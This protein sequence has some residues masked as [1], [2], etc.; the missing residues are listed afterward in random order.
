MSKTFKVAVV[1]CGGIA[2][3][4]HLPALQAQKNVEIVWF[5]DIIEERA[6]KA[7]EKYGAE[8]A[9]VTTD[10]KDVIADETVDVVHVLT[11][12]REH[13][14]ITIDAL[15]SGKHV[16]C[17]KPMAKTAKE[18]A[19]MVAA[20]KRSG[21]KLSIGYQGRHRTDS[22]YLKALVEDGELGEIYY[23]KAQAIRRRGV[24]TWGV[25]LDEDAQGGGPLIDIG[26][27][28]LDLTLWLMDNYEVD[29]VVGN[30]YRKLGDRENAANGF[31]PWD[32]K[33]F[34]VEDSAFGFITMKNGATI[35]L[36]SS[37]AL[38]I[39]DPIESASVLCGTEGGADMLD[40]LRINGE[41]HSRLYEW[42]PELQSGG[43]AFYDGDANE[44]ESFRECRLFYKSIEDNS[45]PVVTPEQALVV[46]QVLEAIYES[47]KTRRPVYFDEAFPKK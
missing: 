42:K 15:D 26:T 18:A 36:E 34:T 3:G 6:V 30:S 23:A 21:K 2:E 13:S 5:C 7:A 32:P 17:E 12:N 29:Y 37:W 28:A 45:D 40:G 44:R 16:L 9:K 8:G 1:G 38:N 10:Y 31:G 39:L 43:V 22:Q 46:T 11:P 24:P 41:K 25:F 14:F 27:H 47:A 35:T 20:A 33:E 4:K 19:E